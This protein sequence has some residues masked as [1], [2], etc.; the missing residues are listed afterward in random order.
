MAHDVHA[1][2]LTESMTAF[3]TFSPAKP[4]L[5]SA[6][7]T[8]RTTAP[9]SSTEAAKMR[10]ATDYDGG[11]MSSPPP[12]MMTMLLQGSARRRY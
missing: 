2:A 6:V 8:S 1:P 7:P 12:Y 5:A 3:G 11:T 10:T 9:T 4:A